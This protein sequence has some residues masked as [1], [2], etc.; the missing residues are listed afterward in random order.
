MEVA[1]HQ[2]LLKTLARFRRPQCQA[3]LFAQ[4]ATTGPDSFAPVQI[5][6]LWSYQR[7]G[8]IID[9]QQD[10]IES[11]LGAWDKFNNITGSQIN[12]FVLQQVAVEFPKK[13]TIPF[14][15]STQQLTHDHFR[16]GGQYIESVAHGLALAQA[17]DQYAGRPA[18]GQSRTT[19]ARQFQFRLMLATVHQ[20]LT[21][22]PD[23]ELTVMLIEHHLAFI[24]GPGRSYSYSR[25]HTPCQSVHT[26]IV[27]YCRR[28]T[29]YMVSR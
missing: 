18:T 22:D 12:S 28:T 20:L 25:F 10:R 2:E 8:T 11:A 14:N 19:Q 16:V 3:P 13:R 26:S 24:R 23:R 9:I 21:V 4:R 27:F 29:V 7:T 17:T 15:H 5:S 6:I 1:A